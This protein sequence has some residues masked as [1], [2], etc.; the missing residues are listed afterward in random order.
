MTL[1][2]PYSTKYRTVPD[3][4]VLHR[5]F[6]QVVWGGGGGGAGFKG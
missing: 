3:K 1:I 2:Q 6:E 5:A 4:S